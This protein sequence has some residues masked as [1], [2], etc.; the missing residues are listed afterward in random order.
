MGE[1][2]HLLVN[3]SMGDEFDLIGRLREFADE[4]IAAGIDTAFGFG[5]EH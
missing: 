5:R 4:D 3:K 2:V 1:E